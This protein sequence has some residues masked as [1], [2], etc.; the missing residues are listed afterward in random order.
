MEN[1]CKPSVCFE[2]KFEISMDE[3]D[4]FDGDLEEKFEAVSFTPVEGNEELLV[5]SCFMRTKPEEG[6]I[7]GIL[8]E[9]GKPEIG[10]EIEKIESENWLSENQVCFPPVE[11]GE[12]FIY[13]VY[14]GDT[15]IPDNKKLIAL[16]A[17]TAFGSG[18][19]QTT[20]GCLMAAIDL[21]NQGLEF[22]K[23][24]DMGCGSGVLSMG[25]YHLWRNAEIFA[26]DI[27]DEAVRVTQENI[28]YNKI[29]NVKYQQSNGY[30]SDFVRDNGAYDFVFANILA[31]PLI[32]MAGNLYDNLK[33][34]GYAI[35]SGLLNRQEEWVIDEHKKN[36]LEL[37]KVFQIDGWSA[38]LMKKEK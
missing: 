4:F 10:Y 24:L 38:I 29:E 30:D 15:I 34:G 37:V 25:A 7:E 8:K 23:I 14:A 12:L 20:K 32:A 21:K 3:F 2:I 35:L 18:E 33:I 13:N 19:H 1:S 36:G 17:T 16:N 5:V 11:V 26:V 31:E 28:K 27:D 6:Y 9:I 22:V